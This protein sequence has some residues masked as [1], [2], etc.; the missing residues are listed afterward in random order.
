[1]TII[2][3]L[4]G[5]SSGISRLEV[6]GAQS[7]ADSVHTGVGGGVDTTDGVVV[8]DAAREH[9]GGAIRCCVMSSSLCA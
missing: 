8:D 6:A 2:E 7:V 4:V 3:H 9:N 1:M 5:V